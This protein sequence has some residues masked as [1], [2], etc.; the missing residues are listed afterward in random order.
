MDKSTV[1]LCSCEKGNEMNL[2]G[3][4]K[5]TLLDFPG[6]T[7]CTVFL[8]GCNFRCP[9]CHNAELA[10]GT[11]P[12]VMD[13]RELLAFLEKRTGLLDGVCFTGGEPLLSPGLAEL[14]ASVRAMGYAI[15]LDTDGAFPERLAGLFSRHLVDY[16][17]MDV[18]NSPARYAETC[19]V[20]RVDLAPIRESISLLIEGKVDYEFRTT[21]VRELHD[22]ASFAAIGELIRGAKQYFLQC[23]TDR[24]TVPFAGLSA[25]DAADLERWAG[26]VRPF[27]GAVEI[28]GAS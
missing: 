2:Y 3:L 1:P 13:D 14:M 22:D 9:F 26:I 8:A 16:V 11:A 25:P 15:K 23:F 5:L 12:A 6:H 17:A 18:K 21:A 10:D 7:A 27:V 20:E 28:R 24:D 4:Q 19:G